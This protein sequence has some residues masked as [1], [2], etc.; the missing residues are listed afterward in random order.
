MCVQLC[1]QY[2]WHGFRF[3]VSNRCMFRFRFRYRLRVRFEFRLR[4]RLRL[5]IRFRQHDKTQH[6]VRHVKTRRNK[7]RLDKTRHD[8]IRKDQQR[9]NRS[10]APIFIR[11]AKRE[12]KGN[13]NGEAKRSD[14]STSTLIGDSYHGFHLHQHSPLPSQLTPALPPLPPRCHETRR[15]KL[16]VQQR[17]FCHIETAKVIVRAYFWGLHSDT[18]FYQKC[19]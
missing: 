6:E 16:T 1:F 11:I 10:S 4:Q 18:G 8:T 5:G 17:D 15:K 7:T 2:L 3:R 13:K 12:E 9:Q 19:F 14:V